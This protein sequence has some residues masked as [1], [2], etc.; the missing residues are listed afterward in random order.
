VTVPAI[1]PV[2]PAYNEPGMRTDR[3]MSNSDLMCVS[4]K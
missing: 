4:I 3:R 1:F 2:F